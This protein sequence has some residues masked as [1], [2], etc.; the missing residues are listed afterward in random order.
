MQVLRDHLGHPINWEDQKDFNY[1]ISAW[2]VAT[3]AYPELTNPNGG[4]YSKYS[5]M[6]YLIEKADQ[7]QTLDAITGNTPVETFGADWETLI[8][9]WE[10]ELRTQYAWLAEYFYI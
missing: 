7:Q 9:D 2:V 3:K 10:A 4:G 6:S 1:I 5:F 8:A